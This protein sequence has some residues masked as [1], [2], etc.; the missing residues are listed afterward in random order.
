[1]PKWIMK[2]THS[3]GQARLTIPKDLIDEMK[4]EKLQVVQ[5]EKLSP[6]YIGVRGFDGSEEIKARDQRDQHGVD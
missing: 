6:E 4:W 3:R 2:L 5:I 1:M